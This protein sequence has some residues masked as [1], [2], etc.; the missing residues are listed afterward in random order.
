MTA[1]IIVGVLACTRK[2]SEHEPITTTYFT[3]V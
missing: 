3:F 1:K 2:T